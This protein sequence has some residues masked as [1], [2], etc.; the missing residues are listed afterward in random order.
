MSDFT[1]N[2]QWISIQR[3]IDYTIQNGVQQKR[4]NWS[5]IRM[6]HSD[7]EFVSQLGEKENYLTAY[8]GGTTET[9]YRPDNTFVNGVMFDTETNWT[10][11]DT[12]WFDTGFVVNYQPVYRAMNQSPNVPRSGKITLLMPLYLFG[13]ALGHWCVVDLFPKQYSLGEFTEWD[14]GDVGFVSGSNNSGDNPDFSEL[15]YDNTSCA[16]SQTGFSAYS[17]DGATI[18]D[19]QYGGIFDATVTT[20][21]LGEHP[22]PTQ[23]LCT[24]DIQT[25]EN[26]GVDWFTQIQT[27]TYR[28]VWREA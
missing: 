6:R 23:F 7:Q 10:S 18:G 4:S 9:V 25:Y 21:S 2:W 27:W 12:V 1:S 3:G 20:A 16:A 24:A 5:L 28:S 15:A 14:S 22:D 8:N 13:S 26:R 19:N 11:T 17:I